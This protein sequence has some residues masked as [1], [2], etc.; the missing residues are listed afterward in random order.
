MRLFY[1]LAPIN[2]QKKQSAIPIKD[3]L[4]FVKHNIKQS[5]TLIFRGYNYNAPMA[6]ILMMI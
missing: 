2:K 5:N 4:T 6:I 3:M 1:E